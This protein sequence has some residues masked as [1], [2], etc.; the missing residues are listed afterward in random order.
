MVEEENH[1]SKS[2]DNFF[3][4][5]CELYSDNTPNAV[6]TPKMYY[7]HAQSVR[8]GEAWFRFSHQRAISSGRMKVVAVA[9]VIGYHAQDDNGDRLVA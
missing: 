6:V 2:T 1:M 8:H 3:C 7:F 4:A 5:A 9:P